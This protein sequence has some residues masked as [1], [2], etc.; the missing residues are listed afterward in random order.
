MKPLRER[1]IIAERPPAFISDRVLR[2]WG[3]KDSGMV[4]IK[5]K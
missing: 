4:I 5:K 1:I 2:V 3:L